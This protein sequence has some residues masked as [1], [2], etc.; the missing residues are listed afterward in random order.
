MNQQIV[1]LH[2]G[3]LRFLAPWQSHA[4]FGL[5]FVLIGAL[6]GLEA[7]EG[8][9]CRKS[10][11]RS[12]IFPAILVLLGYGMLFVVF[13]EPRA[14]IAH[15]SMGTAM[16]AGGWAEARF[17]LGAISRAS[18]DTFIV[19]A[20]VLTFLDT[21][22]FHLS[23]TPN[24]GAK[25]AHAGLAVLALVIAALRLYEGRQ[26]EVRFRSLLV[27]LAVIAVGFDLWLDAFFQRPL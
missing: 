24:L 6:M 10:R 19:T 14:R 26:T 4:L 2:A 20:L 27:S 22:L 11:L 15:F 8:D 13:V 12:L 21:V 23:G 5:G 1:L 16:I 7:F 3:N 17:R 9:A 25:S 18:A